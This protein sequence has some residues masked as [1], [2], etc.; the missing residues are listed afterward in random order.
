MSKLQKPDHILFIG[1]SLYTDLVQRAYLERIYPYVRRAKR[2]ERFPT[3]TDEVR[4]HIVEMIR[5]I[6]HPVAIFAVDKFYNKIIEDLKAQSLEGIVKRDGN[7]YIVQNNLFLIK[8]VSLF[9]KLPTPVTMIRNRDISAFKLFGDEVSL[10]ILE[11][12]LLNHAIVT[13]VLPTWYNIEILDNLGETILVELSKELDIKILPISSVRESL[14]KY[15]SEAKKSL[16]FAESC[17]GGLLAA[18]FTAIQGASKVINGSVVAYSNEIKM[19]W[20]NVPAEVFEKYG[21]VSY[22]C[23]S[24]M[25]DGIYQKTGADIVVAISGIAGPTGATATKKVGT[26]FIGVKNDDDKEVVE[27]FFKGDRNFIQEQSARKA[28]EMILYSERDFFNFFEK[29]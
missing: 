28:I 26:V 6:T 17:T 2:V 11:D 1:A 19:D 24:Y 8:K 14:I 7:I 20:L 9:D 23:V 25:L 10:N 4:D 21:A 16:S 13:K 29:S 12:R 27:Y 3:Y 18:K 15:L 22:E 5:E